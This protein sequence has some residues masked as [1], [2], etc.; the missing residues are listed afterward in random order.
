[1]KRCPLQR[2]DRKA[3]EHFSFSAQTHEFTNCRQGLHLDHGGGQD[4]E[5]FLRPLLIFR[6]QTEKHDVDARLHLLL[7]VIIPPEHRYIVNALADPAR[8][9]TQEPPHLDA[10][11]RMLSQRI[12][13][14]ASQ[15]A[16]T[17]DQRMPLVVPMSAKESERRS[18]E[19]RVG[20]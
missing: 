3:L 12:Y 13:H 2:N 18:E 14:P 16:G 4:G 1:M 15:A 5:H 10:Q 20:K 11:L 19:R 6:G 8:V 9:R 7:E 17:D